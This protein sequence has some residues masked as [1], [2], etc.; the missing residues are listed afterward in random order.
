[1]LL[2]FWRAVGGAEY[3]PIPSYSERNAVL[4][5]LVEWIH[6]YSTHTPYWYLE[7]TFVFSWACDG[8]TTSPLEHSS[9]EHLL[10]SNGDWR[11]HQQ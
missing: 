6:D 1:M 5:A 7:D 2:R 4:S 8:D 11:Q 3:S 9:E 10:M